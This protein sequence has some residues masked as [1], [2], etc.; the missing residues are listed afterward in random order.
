MPS[1]LHPGVYI[2]EIPSGAKPIEGVGTSTA[3]FVGYTTKG[4]M[5]EP[6]KISR[7]DTYNGQFGGLRDTGKSGEGDPMGF[8]VYNFFLNGGTTAYIVRITQADSADAAE[9]FLIHPIDAT[10]MI[11]FEAANPGEWGSDLELRFA[12]KEDSTTLFTL[13]VGVLDNEGEFKE[14]ERFTDL[15]VADE[16][17]VDFIES[18]VNDASQLV[19][20]EVQ[21]VS[22]HLLGVSIS[23]DLAAVADFSV[24]NSRTMTVTVDGTA[25]TAAFAADDFDNGST[26]TEV[27]NRIE[28]L[29]RGSVVAN[30]AVEDF[31]CAVDSNRLVLTSGTRLATSAV[32]VSGPG[33]ATDGSVNLLLGTANDGT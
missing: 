7:W 13:K 16:N 8:A 10:R 3:A 25:R 6:T 26:L 29:V 11:K 14:F 31:T 32:V 17:A 27:A 24:L 15:T 9:G 30:P 28:E 2:E 21:D 19:Q 20:V 12:L 22:P 33:D 18:K 1:Y 23:Q 5:G 4:P